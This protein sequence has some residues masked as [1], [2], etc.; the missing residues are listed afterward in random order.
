MFRARHALVPLALFLTFGAAPGAQAA[1]TTAARDTVPVARMSVPQALLAATRGEILIVDVRPAPQRAVGHIRGDVHVPLER[2]AATASLPAGKRLVF[3]C[4]CGAEE[5][6]LDAARA[7]LA[8]APRPV[9]VLVGG[10]DAWRAAGGPVQVDETWDELFKV[11]RDPAGWGKTPVDSAR[12]RYTVDHATAAQGA[13][14]GCL[15]CVRDTTARGFAGYVQK[16]DA[17][18]LRGRSV[19]LTAMVRAADVAP[20]G[21]FLWIGSEDAQGRMLSMTRPDA[22]PFSGTSDWQLRQV[23]AVVPP[24]AAKVLIGVSVIRWGRIWVDDVRLVAPENR[25]QPRVR[26]VVVNHSFEE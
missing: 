7:V 21:A 25:D 19:T 5:L 6:A 2:L 26:A 14:S 18:A 12:C 9:A 23:S 11:D 15:S 20:P 16:V 1:P 3:Y 17:R 24:D 8:N 10:F 22:D 4:S 13:A